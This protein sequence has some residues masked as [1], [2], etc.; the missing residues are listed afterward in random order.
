MHIG[1][2]S[3]RLKFEVHLLATLPRCTV[4][5]MVTFWAC[6]TTLTLCTGAGEFGIHTRRA[7]FPASGTRSTAFNPQHQCYEGSHNNQS[8][9]YMGLHH[10]GLRMSARGFVEGLYGGLVVSGCAPLRGWGGVE[11]RTLS[12][13]LS[14]TLSGS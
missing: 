5:V 6:V 11:G 2:Y 4:D 3:E 7:I 12:L 14:L 8:D 10:A 1:N 13:T 9:L